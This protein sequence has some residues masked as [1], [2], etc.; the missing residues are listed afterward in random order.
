MRGLPWYRWIQRQIEIPRPI[1]LP[2]VV[3]P[4]IAVALA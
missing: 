4:V 3:L 2:V 1:E